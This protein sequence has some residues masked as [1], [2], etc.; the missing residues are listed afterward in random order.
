MLSATAEHFNESSSEQFFVLSSNGR[1]VKLTNA[2]IQ[3]A[4]GSKEVDHLPKTEK[5]AD[6]VKQYAG[7]LHPLSLNVIKVRTISRT[8]RRV[9]QTVQVECRDGI[10]NLTDAPVEFWS[11][12]SSS[13]IRGKIVGQEPNGGLFYI[14]FHQSVESQYLPGRLRIDRGFLL[15]ELGQAVDALSSY[16]QLAKTLE[17]RASG[18]VIHHTNSVEVTNQLLQLTPPWTRLL[19]G[20]PGAGKT[21]GVAHFIK[22]LIREEPTSKVLLVA[23]SNLAVDVALQEVVQQFETGHE[24]YRRLISKRRVTRYGYPRKTEILQRPEL[25]GPVGLD[26]LNRKVRELANKIEA[27][28]RKGDVSGERVA[29]LRAELLEVQETVKE[30]VRTH[31]ENSWVVATTTT[32]AYMASSPISEIDWDTVIVDEVTMA[33]PALCVFLSSLA[34]RRLLLTGD[35]RQLGPVFE[36][37]HE[38]DDEAYKWMGRD[39]FE[40]IGVSYGGGEARD[41][42]LSDQRLVQIRSQRRCA[43]QM[44]NKVARLYPEVSNLADDTRL[45]PLIQLPPRRG[46][47]V[48]L[49]DTDNT[50]GKGRCENVRGS[51]RNEYTAGLALEVASAIAGESEGQPPSIAVIS[52]YRAQTDFL[53]AQIRAEN[54]GQSR[55]FDRVEVG[56]VHQFQGS[57]ADVVIFDLVDGPGRSRLGTLLRGD[58]GVRLTTVAATRGRGKLILI[59]NRRWFKQN[60]MPS[61]NRL[62]WQ[63]II[64]Q[65][66]S[67]RIDVRPPKPD[68]RAHE[69]KLRRCESPIEKELYHAMKRVP[70]LE[71]VEPQY[72]IRD[73]RGRIV[74]RADF[75]F[76]DLKFAVYCDGARWHLKHGRWRR[77]W[78]IRNRLQE[79]GWAFNVFPGSDIKQ[80]PV[81]CAKQVLNTHRSL[82][83]VSTRR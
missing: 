33:P 64:G 61:D 58:T 13:S 23:P 11:D 70:E 76:P 45:S 73:E 68:G 48:V 79:L 50:S 54:K 53:K 83:S 78:R 56:T 12:G 28:E 38:S 39:I 5:I 40:T 51:W 82:S 65:S 37:T 9:I 30:K 15:R 34:K 19:W 80:D 77:D 47:A 62:L 57:E 32:L 35:P 27:E 49:L 3:L 72:V 46:E 8:G 75:A 69:P 16:P 42:D 71:G 66:N 60:A 63:L 44:W 2:G 26:E 36:S 14:A 4:L 31:L 43:S 41:I 74:S 21:Y 6:A 18:K 7:S 22:R 10:T 1:R 24:D 81:R 52:P 55:I 59:A 17:D 29:T 20:P 25:L 67:G